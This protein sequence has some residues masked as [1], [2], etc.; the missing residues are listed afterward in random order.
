[1]TA[2]GE[3]AVRLLQSIDASL[4]A[5]AWHLGYRSMAPPIGMLSA[6]EVTPSTTPSTTPMQVDL[7][8]KYGDPTV[9]A[10]DPRDWAGESMIGRPFSECPPAYLDLVADRLDYFNSS[11]TDEKKRRYNDLDA[12]RARGWAKRLR[13]G[14]KAPLTND[15]WNTGINAPASGFPSD[16]PPLTDD[17]I[18]F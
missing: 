15:E 1:M 7:D 5:I 4:K 8:G 14:W 6:N 2:T 3:D 13:S 10:K 11:E 18:S 17:D 16:A 12:A 9:R